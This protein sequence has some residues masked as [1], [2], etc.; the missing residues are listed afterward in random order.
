MRG[1]VQQKAN[2]DAGSPEAGGSPG[3]DEVRTTEAIPATPEASPG[4]DEGAWGVGKAPP[5]PSHGGGYLGNCTATNFGGP[6][7][8]A[9]DPR[10]D[11]LRKMG[12]QHY[13][14]EVVD[15]IGV[16]AFLA[17]WQIL[18]RQSALW[19]DPSGSGC[20]IPLRR[21]DAYRRFLRNR[22]I[23]A[24]HDAGLSVEEIRR[25]VVAQIGDNLTERH[26]YRLR[27]GA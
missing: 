15:A 16:D 8:R 5:H 6:R 24:L 12:L 9:A 22:Y 11:E 2:Q 25:R 3:R 20:L 18:D 17:M 13:W 27:K 10:A 1:A 7:A 21:F 4:I 23:E 19:L 14:I 26:I